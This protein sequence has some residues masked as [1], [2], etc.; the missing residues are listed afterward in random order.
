MSVL[1][2]GIGV[3]PLCA[4]DFEGVAFFSKYPSGCSVR[5]IVG[6]PMIGTWP[7]TSGDLGD[8]SHKDI[9]EGRL[10]EQPVDRF[11]T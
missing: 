6:A 7:G 1:S 9:Q 2:S 10:Q 8:G 5:G 4:N 3:S 11:F